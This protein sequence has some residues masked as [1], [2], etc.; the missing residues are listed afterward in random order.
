MRTFIDKY[1]RSHKDAVF[2]EQARWMLSPPFKLTAE[3]RVFIRKHHRDLSKGY[4]LH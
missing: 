1:R 3:D 4:V 2:N